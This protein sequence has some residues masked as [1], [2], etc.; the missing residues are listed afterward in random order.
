MINT[1]Y[2]LSAKNNKGEGRGLKREGEL[3]NFFPWGEGVGLNMWR[4]YGNLNLS[5][6]YVVSVGL[7]RSELV[8]Y[9]VWT[10]VAIISLGGQIH[11]NP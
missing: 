2:Y 7:K 5:V 4:V 8:C 6:L 11:A 9:P 10:F 3:I 1:V